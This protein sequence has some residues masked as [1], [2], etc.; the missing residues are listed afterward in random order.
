MNPDPAAGA[1]TNTA[2]P[3]QPSSHQPHTTRH[4]HHQGR[5]KTDHHRHGRHGRRRRRTHRKHSRTTKHKS[6]SRR[7]RSPST[8]TYSYSST[9][10][11]SRSRQPLDLRPN[12]A[13][14]NADN[15]NTSATE[16][17]LTPVHRRPPNFWRPTSHFQQLPPQQ[18]LVT[19]LDFHAD[20]LDTPNRPQHHYIANL[21]HDSN[22]TYKDISDFRQY[23]YAKW[24][25][26]TQ[27]YDQF[28]Y[29]A[30]SLPYLNTKATQPSPPPV[31]RATSTDREVA[32]INACHTGP[33]GNIQHP[34][35]RP[36]PPQHTSLPKLPWLFCPGGPHCSQ[37]TTR[38]RRICSHHGNSLKTPTPSS[39]HS[40]PGAPPQN[41]LRAAKNMP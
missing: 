10:S 17:P 32:H 9:P 8:S 18:Q 26:T 29:N 40:W 28:Q 30:I 2:S 12:T 36:F 24:N 7:H 16:Y 38:P 5:R 3:A 22:I 33:V 14:S 27:Q 25:D 21:L 15:L 20:Q 13:T 11:R 23:T 1:A 31:S 6:S 35:T 4:R 37:P 34:T 41:S 39:S 19:W